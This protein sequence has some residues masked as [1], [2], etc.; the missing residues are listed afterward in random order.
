MR[1]L[2]CLGQL[3]TGCFTSAAQGL[4]LPQIECENCKHPCALSSLGYI[5][6]VRFP[7]PKCK[8]VLKIND[9]VAGRRGSCPKCGQRFQLP[10]VLPSNPAHSATPQVVP[11]SE[12]KEP[13]SEEPLPVATKRPLSFLRRMP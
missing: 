2:S 7:C 13:S 12:T 10:E 6:M 9:S 8:A 1:A 4:E 11:A 5:A 3:A